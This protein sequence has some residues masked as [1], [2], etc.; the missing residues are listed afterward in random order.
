MLLVPWHQNQTNESLHFELA[1]VTASSGRN[2]SQPFNLKDW[3]VQTMKSC[4]VISNNVFMYISTV[5][6]ITKGATNLKI[7]SIWAGLRLLS[8]MAWLTAETRSFRHQWRIHP[9]HKRKQ[10]LPGARFL[11]YFSSWIPGD[12]G[13][14][15]ITIQDAEEFT[16][17]SVSITC[18]SQC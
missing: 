15:D 10:A 5:D 16:L 11:W 8:F 17:W 14:P 2:H 12:H 1:L 7:S 4:L 3:E 9:V 6:H 13:I 18:V